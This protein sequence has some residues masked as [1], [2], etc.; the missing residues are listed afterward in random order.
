MKSIT[1][2][3]RGLRKIPAIS[4]SPRGAPAA[5]AL[6]AVALGALLL[7]GLC[8]CVARKYQLAKTGTPPVQVLNVDFPQTAPPLRA[9]LVALISYGG[10]GSW[11]REALW[12]EYVLAL[13]ND[14]ERPITLESVTLRD[15]TGMAFAA[16]V[17]P[18]AIEKQTK[19]ME[20]Q[21][22]NR[23]EA[24][25][26]AAAPGALIVG[27]GAAAVAATASAATLPVAPGI[28]GATLAGVYVLPVYYVA[29]WGINE[30]N[31]YRVTKEFARRR[32]PLPLTLA[33]GET[34]T[35][36]VFYPLVRSPG[37]L[38]LDWSGGA[39]DGEVT[40]PLEFLRTLHVSAPAVSVSRRD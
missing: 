32:L 30:H 24:F 6:V 21:Y 1:V 27:T 28:A 39:G 13:H 29:V 9:T 36:S 3:P 20:K 34:R 23:G 38:R 16:G 14:G 37:A 7:G 17:D 4:R 8:G 11:K 19:I 10:P 33:P 15:S 25:V 31:K 5:V 18:W 35:A 26:R 40:L 2:A 12:D 22:R